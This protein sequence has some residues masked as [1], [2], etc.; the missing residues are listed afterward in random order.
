MTIK[1]EMR[2]NFNGNYKV[3]RFKAVISSLTKT[4]FLF[5]FSHS[6]AR[7]LKL[8][9][10]LQPIWVTHKILGLDSKIKR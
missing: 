2:N 9:C 5:K 6:D 8:N 4:T 1:L 10:T 3:R 7:H